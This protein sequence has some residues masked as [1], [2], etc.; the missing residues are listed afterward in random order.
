MR[1]IIIC[2]AIFIA[3][4]VS[5]PS[6]A[7]QKTIKACQEEWRANRAE[8]QAKGVTQKAYVEQCRAAGSTGQ[9]AAGR[10]SASERK[11]TT[12]AAPAAGQ[13]TVRACQE[14]WRANRAENQAKGITQKAYVE[15]CRVA[16]RV[17]QPA[18]AAPRPATRRATTGAAPPPTPGSVRSRPAPSAAATPMGAN[19]YATETQAKFRCGAGMVV[20]ANLEFEDLSL[21]GLQGLRQY[22]KRRVYVRAGCDRSGNARRKKRK[23]SLRV[24]RSAQ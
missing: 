8:N 21:P 23:T 10:P 22:E 13:K 1:S 11:G 4:V 18:T 7:Q 9:P 2:L 5:F 24:S 15:Q 19:Q 17:A 6:Y 3:S 16:G 12:G 14:E 20:W